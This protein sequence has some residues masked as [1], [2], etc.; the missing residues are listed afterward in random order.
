MPV[1]SVSVSGYRSIQ[2]LALPIAPLT[3]LV[4][5]N[6]VGK[7]N[8]YRSLEVLRSAA[9]GT[10]TRRIAEEGGAASV[11]WAGPQRYREPMRLSFKADID[12]LEYR[13]EIGLP[14][15]SEIALC[16]EQGVKEE[17]IRLRAGGKSTVVMSRQG[18]NLWLL[19]SDGARREYSNVLL[20]SETAIASL[21]DA[22]R[23]PALEYIRRE[24]LGWRFYHSFR[25]DSASPLRNNCL[26][27]ATP[28]LAADGSDLAAVFATLYHLRGDAKAVEQA[29]EEAMPGARLLVEVDKVR[30]SF[31]LKFADQPRAFGVHELSD[32]TLRYL[33]LV[34]ALCSYRLP[35]FI[36]LNEPE[37]SLHPDL[38]PALAGLIARASRRTRV[39]VVTHSKT[40]ASEITRLTGVKAG[41]VTK[42]RGATEVEMPP[43]GVRPPPIVHD[44]RV[45]A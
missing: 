34:G 43:A 4:G 1:H 26:A 41:T 7:T 21:R 22:D 11:L 18:P 6:A 39:W 12:A 9:E 35:D 32:G 40:L 45:L 23:F 24:L 3:V 33:C 2:H 42:R 25:T 17:E 10:I 44:E 16:L 27:V 30:A 15:L 20:P 37:T 13:L 31:S 36:A 14:M 19:D 5:R 28:T 8:I 29:I 38:I